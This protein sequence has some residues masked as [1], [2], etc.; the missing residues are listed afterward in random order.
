LKEI[1]GIMERTKYSHE[2]QS[3]NES[4][5]KFKLLL[6]PWTCD[7]PRPDLGIDLI[8]QPFNEKSRDPQNE[9]LTLFPK[10]FLVQLKST[11]KSTNK[12]KISITIKHLETWRDQKD[13]VMLVKYYADEDSFYYTWVDQIE[14]KKGQKSQTIGLPHILN[15]DTVEDEKEKILDYILPPEWQGETVYDPIANTAT[16]PV[17]DFGRDTEITREVLESIMQKVEQDRLLF[18]E[19]HK[20]KELLSTNP[21][22]L[23]ARFKLVACYLKLEDENAVYSE[24]GVLINQF[25]R[26]EAKILYNILKSPKRKIMYDLQELHFVRYLKWEQEIPEGVKVES[27]VILDGTNYELEYKEG[28]VI[29]PIQQFATFQF[30]LKVSGKQGVPF[31]FK[32]L[33]LMQGMLNSNGELLH[34]FGEIIRKI[35]L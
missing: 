33:C 34:E 17:I 31:T 26:S 1:V 13:P 27:H 12:D 3:E 22:N 10:R 28:G 7:K 9:A 4:E 8:I 19:I 29:L 23:E 20:L 11:K 30:S 25:D 21:N 32:N 5:L 16:A 15:G 6:H 2:Q 14:V 35:P 18:F 24:L